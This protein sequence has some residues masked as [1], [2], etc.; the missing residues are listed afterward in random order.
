MYDLEF[1][2]AVGQGQALESKEWDQCP[3]FVAL[4]LNTMAEPSWAS[5]YLPMKWRIMVICG[6]PNS[7]ALF[8]ESNGIIYITSDN[9]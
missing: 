9:V 8:W 7:V 3:G 1:K 2:I 4:W 6:L 5:I